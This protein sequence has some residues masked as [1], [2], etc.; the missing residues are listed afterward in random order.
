MV[1]TLNSRFKLK[2]HPEENQKRKTEQ[3]GYI[4]VSYQI[5]IEAICLIV[6]NNVS[7]VNFSSFELIHLWI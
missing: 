1:P 5:F 3:Q 6:A 7:F 2:Y 4:K